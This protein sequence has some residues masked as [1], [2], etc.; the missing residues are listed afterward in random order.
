MKKG[1]VILLTLIFCFGV[2]YALN[3][4][5]FDN[6]S[7]A[8]IEVENNSLD[9]PMN[10][11]PKIV[12][13]IVDSSGFLIDGFFKVS[14]ILTY[15]NDSPVVGENVL[16][17]S[18]E[19]LI[20]E[21]MTDEFGVSSIVFN[22]SVYGVGNYTISVNGTFG[23]DS[24]VLEIGDENLEGN[25]PV[26]D[27]GIIE[28]KV[29]D[30]L[31][32]ED[33]MF[34]NESKTLEDIDDDSL[35]VRDFDSMDVLDRGSD[36]NIYKGKNGTKIARISP[37][38]INYLEDDSYEPINSTIVN[39]G[40]EFDWCVRK[41]VYWADFKEDSSS[42]DVV[43]FLFNGSYISYTPLP[44]RFV[45]GDDEEIVSEVGKVDGEASENEFVYEDVYGKGLSLG[46]G[47]HNSFLK[48]NLVIDSLESLGEPNM[49]D[50]YL[51]LDF[52]FD[53]KSFGENKSLKETGVFL[54]GR[55]KKETGFIGKM[56]GEDVEESDEKNLRWDKSERL[57]V[58][59]EALFNKSDGE[60]FAFK[61]PTP[62]AVD[63]DG[64]MIELEY[65]FEE[66][67]GEMIVS[68]L[69]PWDWLADEERVFPVK[70]DPTSS[71]VKDAH[72]G[73]STMLYS[74]GYTYGFTKN[75]ANFD[76][77]KYGENY[78]RG[79]CKWDIDA[80][81]GE[82]DGA[83]SIDALN[84][85]Y[86]IASGNGDDRALNFYFMDEDSVSNWEPT[87]T[88]DKQALFNE[89]DDDTKI[90]GP[91]SPSIYSTSYFMLDTEPIENALNNNEDVFIGIKGY[92]SGSEDWFRLEG[93]QVS[94]EFVIDV[95]YTCN[96]DYSSCQGCLDLSDGY[97]CDCSSECNGGWCYGA[98]PGNYECSDTGCA[99]EGDFAPESANCCSG[100]SW[101]SGT[102]EC[103]GATCGDGVIEGSETCDDDNTNNGD[104]CSS[105][106]SIE[107]GYSCSGTPSTCTV[108]CGDGLIRGSEECDDGDTSSND[109][110]D[111]S[112][113]VES[114][115]S[116]GG[117]PSSC[118]E[119]VEY[120]SGE[121]NVFVEDSSG[122][123]LE[124]VYA[125]LNGGSGYDTDSD[126]FQGFYI[127]NEDCGDT[128]S[129]QV[130]C[131]DQSTVC[132]S[133]STRINDEGGYDIDSMYFVCDVCSSKKDV[134]IDKDDISFRDAGDDVNLSVV[135]K[136][137]GLSGNINIKMSCGSELFSEEVNLVNGGDAVV[138]FVEYLGACNKINIWFDEVSGEDDD[139]NNRIDDL[140]VIDV[141]KVRLFVDTG[142]SLID[143]EIKEFIG[144]YAEIV[145][146][147]GYDVLDIHVGRKLA[148]DYNEK[149]GIKNGLV[150][151]N[152][153]TEGVPYVGMVVR[154]DG[155]AYVFGNELDGTLAAV[156][157]LVDERG[158][159][160]N[161]KNINNDKMVY[162][163][164]EDIGAISVFDYL[165]TDEN[166]EFYRKN[167]VEFADIVDNVLRKQ[168]FN[169]AI[170]RVLTAN[171]NTSLRLKNV[172]H[173]LSP[174]FKD[175][176][177]ERPVVTGHGLFSDLF[178]MEPLALK[179]AK[180]EKYDGEFV[181]DVWMAE[182][183]GGP[184]TEC[185]NCP[186]YN[187]TDILD[188]YWPALF[189]GV[190]SYTNQSELDFIG[191]SGGATGGT[192]YSRWEYGK[193]NVGY[194]V[195]ADGD[196]GGMDLP[197][198]FIDHMVLIAPMLA[199]N[200]TTPFTR[201]IDEY[202]DRVNENLEGI[203]HISSELL[204]KE[205]ARLATIR[206]D[207]SMNWDPDLDCAAL[208]GGGWFFL[209]GGSKT[210]YNFWRDIVEDVQDKTNENPSFN[211]LNELLMIKGR[212]GG[213][214]DDGVV[215]D[216]D[217]ENVYDNSNVN[218]KYYAGVWGWVYKGAHYDTW[219][220]NEAYD[221]LMAK[222]FNDKEYNLWDKFWYIIKYED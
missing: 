178:S 183:K 29:D 216:A 148:P 67:G 99:D 31:A 45:S 112:C 21:N 134:L 36:Y 196:W 108:D 2:V 32:I 174:V 206:F 33:D 13:L 1:I 180:D 8:V 132:G 5:L 218:E 40:C 171:D 142:Y 3:G 124:G 37:G 164:E 165:H 186:N 161:E 201:C 133:D 103:Y 190:L 123:Q 158:E 147:S 137:I 130:K 138:N 168:T 215:P 88:S 65:V 35:K 52:A 111:S 61:M 55:V 95:S 189:G 30:G 204:G 18:D 198:G 121:I 202:G 135:V 159:Y 160:L 213:L 49:K 78:M 181:R 20:G 62:Y 200:G 195:N 26:E 136:S 219:N 182:Y 106:C 77:G 104:G 173:E 74:G 80:I 143:E 211:N 192:S 59:G 169:I 42:E 48:E 72:Y 10:I 153:E 193:S 24:V 34:F 109:G 58:K 187:Y 98:S 68:V 146:T 17:Y 23:G 96:Q 117:E 145:A 177:N 166:D 44:L 54:S 113:D 152:G 141:L 22:G 131:S 100:L 69:T 210:S 66:K 150:R 102:E 118:S 167:N 179:L 97:Y 175:F 185:D 9:I 90:G 6:V 85:K 214:G 205:L 114:G 163:G 207:S 110:C 151:Y 119:E 4:S 38:P 89:I 41:G 92:E 217:L 14:A 51:S 56:F 27:V 125:Y 194:F 11:L 154:E 221:P 73:W 93:Y 7:E 129:V 43:K 19:N 25:E 208:G 155:E 79:Y 47:Y 222:F 16:F 162:L 220:A 64:A 126:G 209:K 39:G 76:I 71:I 91:F 128:H 82:F 87:T 86:Y 197:S 83:N 107:S 184:N 149:W 122:N 15:E 60:G 75:V 176:A 63:A 50:A 115:W 120:C 12:S 116:C 188:Y 144:D 105:S 157:R 140:F 212:F 94:H 199:F 101:N 53:S 84:F 127:V 172:N 81:R 139:S 203:D 191:F 46:Y 70:V 28:K 170:K 156:R 57:S